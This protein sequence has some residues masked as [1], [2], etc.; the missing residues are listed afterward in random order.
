MPQLH[1]YDVIRR[2]VVTEKTTI[3]QDEENQYTFE[4]ALDA[5]KIQIKEAVEIVFDIDPQDILKVRTMIVPAK[6]GT[7]GRTRYVRKKMWKK[8]I[9][10]L[11]PDQTIEV[12][13]I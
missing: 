11:N 2:P 13:D 1:P 7:R 6:L 3:L 12:F 10:T 4:V 5:N 8:A 9:V